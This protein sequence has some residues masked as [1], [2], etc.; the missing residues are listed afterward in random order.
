MRKGL[1]SEKHLITLNGKPLSFTCQNSQFRTDIHLGF[2]PD[3]RSGVKGSVLPFPLVDN[4]DGHTLWLEHVLDKKGH[5]FFWLMWY[6]KG[7]PTIPASCVIE[8]EDLGGLAEKLL[9]AVR[10]ISS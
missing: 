10:T 6:E 9:E 3:S 8:T 4:K 1:M 5:R 2:G 7:T